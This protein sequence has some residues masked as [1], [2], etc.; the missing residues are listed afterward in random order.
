MP[1]SFWFLFAIVVGYLAWRGWRRDLWWPSWAA[2]IM[3]AAWWASWG[4]SN[5][6][7]LTDDYG[8][9]MR[10][11]AHGLIWDRWLAW[12]IIL[13]VLYLPKR[14]LL[15]KLIAAVLV[16]GQGWAILEHASCKLLDDP[17]S[18]EYLA[19]GHWGVDVAKSACARVYGDWFPRI[20]P[21][22]TGSLIA[23]ILWRARQGAKRHDWRG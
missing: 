19:A 1:L 20:E 4:L 5:L 21:L 7:R 14:D 17:F 12:L 2:V 15:A 8:L 22:I 9:A 3:F 18:D 6:W 13:A 16:V 23:W 10:L 11:H